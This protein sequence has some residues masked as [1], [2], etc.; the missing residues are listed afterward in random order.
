MEEDKI[1]TQ[2]KYGNKVTISKKSDGSFYKVTQTNNK[3]KF[4]FMG[5]TY[6][7][8]LLYSSSTEKSY[9]YR[10]NSERELVQDIYGRLF[11][12]RYDEDMRFDGPDREDI[13]WTFVESEEESD[14]LSECWGLSLLNVPFIAGDETG[15]MS[16][17]EYI[18]QKN[19]DDLLASPQQPPMSLFKK[20]I[21]FLKSY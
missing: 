15:W 1:V 8:E 7:Y 16:V 18:D 17:H 19:L 6:S 5:D 9:W 14:K 12:Y 3:S 21:S 20:V 11:H 2:D 13:L 4:I 10:D